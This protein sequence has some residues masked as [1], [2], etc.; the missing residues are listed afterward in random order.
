MAMIETRFRDASFLASEKTFQEKK[1]EVEI[2]ACQAGV[3]S[4]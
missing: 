1:M 3:Y 4:L 2:K